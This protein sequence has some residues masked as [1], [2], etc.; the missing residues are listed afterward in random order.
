MTTASVTALVLLVCMGHD[1]IAKEKMC[2]HKFGMRPPDEFRLYSCAWCY[3]HVSRSLKL[4]ANLRTPYLEA[5]VN[6]STF[7]KGSLLI[8]D[9]KNATCRSMICETLTPDLCDRWSM[10]CHHAEDCCRRQIEAP[11]HTNTTCHRTWD[12]YGCWDDTAPGTT[13]FLSCPSFL[14][15]AVPTRN[16][17]K[18]CNA[19]GTWYKKK[20]LDWTDYTPCLDK[21]SLIS[22]IYLSLGC[23]IASILF[24]VPAFS[25]F[26]MYRSLRRQ[27]RIRL[28]MNFFMS[29]VTSDVVTI[30]WDML[31]TYDRL[32]NEHIPQTLLY[33]NGSGCKVLS[34][35]RIYFKSTN[36]VWMFC[37]G[38]YLH[39]LI[40]N[41]FT[42]PKNLMPLYVTGWGVPLVYSVIYAAIRLVHYNESCWAKSMGHTEWI[43]YAP[44]LLCLVVNLFFLCNILRILLTQLQSHPN[45]PSNFRRALKATFVLIPLFGGQLF[46]TLYRVPPGNPG[47]V[48]YEK[49]TVF[50]INSQG[51]FVALIFCF[52]N[53]EVL[54]HLRKSFTRLKIIR[55]RLDLPRGTTMAT[56]L[57]YI[58]PHCKDESHETDNGTYVFNDS[59]RSSPS[60]KRDKIPMETY[61][62]N[63]L[64]TSVSPQLGPRY[65]K[66]SKV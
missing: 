29:F 33:R 16:A 37:E 1:A 60:P 6:G 35:C 9:V 5:R 21:E 31:V 41:A 57:N 10:C 43:I 4:T 8:P 17:I 56:S 24:L 38:F 13:T 27:H 2:R 15:Y 62:R 14:E 44:N 23:N 40:S 19:D 11:L 20:L 18:Q 65:M 59:P 36:Y 25:I 32:T 50:I 54:S 48:E 46:V 55:S 30:L 51:F 47:A 63:Y 53:S 52:C 49:F 58:H 39:R 64:Y 66:N 28:H 42:P 3:F 26:L 45:E 34:F 61:D 12:G 22:S 7:S